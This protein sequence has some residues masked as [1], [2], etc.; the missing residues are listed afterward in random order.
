MKSEEQSPHAQLPLTPL[1]LEDSWLQFPLDSDGRT[2]HKRPVAQPRAGAGGGGLSP[3]KGVGAGISPQPACRSCPAG[4]HLL[5]Y[6][7]SAS[8]QNLLEGLPLTGHAPELTNS[9]ICGKQRKFEVAR[10]TE[11]RTWESLILQKGQ[12]GKLIRK[13]GHVSRDISG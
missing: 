4:T 8:Q 10:C 9:M 3:T 2:Q 7:P 6:P 11:A 1:S 12:S 5:C 13:T